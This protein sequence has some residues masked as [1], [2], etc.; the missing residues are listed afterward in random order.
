MKLIR[1]FALLSL[2]VILI[3][4]S[5]SVAYA[6]TDVYSDVLADLQVDENFNKDDYPINQTDYSLQIIQIAESNDKSLLVY[7]YQPSAGKNDIVT[8]KIRMS[9]DD[10]R[11][12]ADYNLTLLS[13]NGVFFKYKVDNY[14]ADFSSAQKRTYKIVQL[15]RPADKAL[16]DKV[17]DENNNVISYIPYPCSWTFT[18]VYKDGK[19]YYGKDKLDTILVTDKYCGQLQFSDPLED[20]Y[21]TLGSF[22]LGMLHFVAF[23]TDRQIDKLLSADI[24]YTLVC[25]DYYY[26]NN[27]G[28]DSLLNR[29]VYT[30][31]R[32]SKTVKSTESDSYQNGIFAHKYTWKEIMTV[33]DFI[34]NVVQDENFFFD[35]ELTPSG[36]KDLEGKKWVLCFLTTEITHSSSSAGLWRRDIDKRYF[37]N[38]ET[39]LRLEFKTGGNLY[40]LGVVDNYQTGDGVADNKENYGFNEEY[41]KKWLKGIW[42]EIQDWIKIIAIVLGVILLIIILCFIFPP[43]W[44]LIKVVFRI[45]FAP[46]RWLFGRSSARSNKSKYKRR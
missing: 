12:Y 19:I 4:T 21:L 25:R 31:E 27:A 41:W 35:S 10:G 20:I 43:V 38:D 24:E 9:V 2:F 22:K 45:L 16:G 18:A 33:E 40:N 36:K 28:V 46:F 37:V 13:R 1:L 34:N 5:S 7:V 6:Y 8:K 11:S 17:V 44:K 39:I 3:P 29:D 26:E 23:N 32:K 42:D 14:I 30:S 15:M